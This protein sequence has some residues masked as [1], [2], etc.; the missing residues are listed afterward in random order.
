MA[1]HLLASTYTGYG[2]HVIPPYSRT[3]IGGEQDV[4]G[5]D[6]Y[7]ISPIAFIAS[8]PMYRF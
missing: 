1:F 2:G 5:F 7:G 8:R 6:F 3:Y 4:R